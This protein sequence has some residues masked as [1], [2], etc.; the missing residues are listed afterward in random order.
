MGNRGGRIHNAETRS[1]T[2]RRWASRRWIICVTRFRGRHREIMAPNSYTELFFLDEV[3]A[4][5]AGHRPCFECQREKAKTFA[6]AFSVALKRPTMG[7][8]AMDICLHGERLSGNIQPAPLSGEQ[9][10]GLP[11]GAMFAHD[12]R[13]FCVAPGGIRQ[14]HIEGYAQSDGFPVKQHGA[15]NS[16][17]RLLTPPSIVAALHAGYQPFIHP[18]ALT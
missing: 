18:S 17:Y 12:D 5:A 4:L 2:K 9:I 1:L 14:W 6:A 7:A 10:D 15:Q 3:T 11:I 13:Y 8:D 16:A